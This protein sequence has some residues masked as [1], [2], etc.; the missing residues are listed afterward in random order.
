M[1][2]SRLGAS[3]RSSATALTSA[4]HTSDTSLGPV[5]ARQVSAQSGF[6]TTSAAIANAAASNDLDFSEAAPRVAAGETGVGTDGKGADAV[7]FV[8]ATAAPGGAE[9]H[10]EGK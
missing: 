4:V 9:G 10:T 6:S 2:P 8:G 1:S 5:L 3:S 7:R